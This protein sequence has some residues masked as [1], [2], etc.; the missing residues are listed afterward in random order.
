MINFEQNLLRLQAELWQ[1]LGNPT[2]LQIIQSLKTSAKSVSEISF[3]IGLA[4][5][6]VSRHL[7]ILRANGILSAHRKAQEVF[8]EIA[9]PKVMDLCETAR[10]LLIE[11]ENQHQ[12]LLHYFQVEEGHR[13]KQDVMPHNRL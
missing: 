9:N 7:S 13:P 3:E 8:Y 4:Q 10:S 2:R 1:S 12:Y 11:R 5:P 6:T